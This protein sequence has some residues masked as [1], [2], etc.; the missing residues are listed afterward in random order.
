MRSFGSPYS[1]GLMKH[2][3]DVD[4]CS[5]AGSCELA[6]TDGGCQFNVEDRQC[7]NCGSPTS[8]D[9]WRRDD[10]GH[11]LCSTCSLYQHL[12][13]RDA[14]AQLEQGISAVRSTTRK[15]TFQR[16]IH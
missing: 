3:S 8:G 7:V 5:V 12:M 9:C 1:C 14:G 6:L 4:A 15:V 13:S 11:Y 2:V 10:T 16:I